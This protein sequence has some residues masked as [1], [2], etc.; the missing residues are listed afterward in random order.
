[1]DEL[2]YNE[3]EKKTLAKCGTPYTYWCPVGK[4]NWKMYIHNKTTVVLPAMAGASL[5]C[6][7]HSQERID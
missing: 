7:E 1:M 2:K 5:V 6:P 3:V 4:H